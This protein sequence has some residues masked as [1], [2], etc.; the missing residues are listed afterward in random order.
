MGDEAAA[1]KERSKVLSKFTKNLNTFV[2]LLEVN[3]PKSLVEPQYE[4][5]QTC[6][7]ALEDAQ[8]KY[9]DATDDIDAD[10]GLNYLDAPG[11]RHTEALKAY[12]AY[13][14]AA[15]DSELAAVK[16]RAHEAGML[17][18]EQRKREADLRLKEEQARAKEELSQR[19]ASLKLEV[20]VGVESFGHLTRGLKDSLGDASEEVKREQWLKVDTE[21]ASLKKRLLEV[22]SS[23]QDAE[24]LTDLKSRFKDEAEVTYLELQKWILPQLKAVVKTSGGG[25]SNST[26]REAISLP[27]FKGDPEDQPFLKFPVWLKQW[28]KLIGDYDEKFWSRLLCEKLDDAACE[29]IVG[30]EDK[31]GEAMEYLKAFYGDPCRVVE[32]VM[33]EVKGPGVIADGDYDSLVAYSDTLARNFIR[34]ENIGLE[35][36]MSNTSVMSSILQKLPR[37]VE[38]KWQEHLA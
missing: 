8:D 31:Y 28:E 13:L 15:D 3:S 25:S 22:V 12:A 4:L 16:Q 29:K 37:S 19:F 32:C 26:K 6:W 38:E 1:K 27:E 23:N 36:E 5:L 10:G 33:Q 17:E 18:H 21:F 30:L 11:V 20:D 34:L 24:D 7:L 9:L 35:H 2:G 14:K